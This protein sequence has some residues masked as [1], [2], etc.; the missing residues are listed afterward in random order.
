[1]VAGK[2]LL[3]WAIIAAKEAQ[4]VGHVVDVCC[5]TGISTKILQS[6]A[7][8]LTGIDVS[9]AMLAQ[10]L[11]IAPAAKAVVDGANVG[12]DYELGDGE[13]LEFVKAAGEKG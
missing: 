10:A 11:N 6:R 1:M 2:T 7:R 9:S 4:N 5:G 12:E 13:S 3:A 8:R